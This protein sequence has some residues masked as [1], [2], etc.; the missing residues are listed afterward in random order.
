MKG[1]SVLGKERPYPCVINSTYTEQCLYNFNGNTFKFD[2]QC[3]VNSYGDSFCPL[4]SG[5]VKY[6]NY[7]PSLENIMKN[8][9]HT[10][11]RNNPKQCPL[12]DINDINHDYLVIKFKQYSMHPKLQKN[13]RCIKETILSDYY[14]YFGNGCYLKIQG[15]KIFIILIALMIF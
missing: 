1:P 11:A 6:M 5:E 15:F 13:S 3:G 14:H 10:L 2:C 4:S 7:L 12:I 8:S 9:C